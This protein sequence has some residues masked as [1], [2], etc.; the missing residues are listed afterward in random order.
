MTAAA[1]CG[2]V[3][4]RRSHPTPRFASAEMRVPGTEAD[5]VIEAMRGSDAHSGH[6]DIFSPNLKADLLLACGA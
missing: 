5:A 2:H 1:T 4:R 6:G 3:A